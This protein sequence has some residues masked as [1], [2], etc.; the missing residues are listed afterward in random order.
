[1]QKGGPVAYKIEL[2]PQLSGIHDAF[3]VSQ[4]RQCLRVPQT[5]EVD[6]Q[7]IELQPDLTYEEYPMKVLD[8][9]QRSTRRRAITMYK[10]QW[11]NHTEDEATWETEEELK[12]RF[13]EQMRYLMTSQG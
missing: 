2:S 5:E 3:H 9:K 1:L 11:S 4:L 10:I 7:G 12:E 6:F 13:P 8:Q